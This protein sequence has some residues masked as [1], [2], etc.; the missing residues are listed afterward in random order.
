MSGARGP[1]VAV[2][3]AVVLGLVYW[4]WLG[5]IKPERERAAEDAKILFKGLNPDDTNEILLRKKG[6]ADVLLRKVDGQW[7]LITPI[8]APA[9][10]VAVGGLV[11]ELAAAKRNEI[12]VD[13]GANLRD[14]GLDQP[15]GEVTFKPA[16]P[17]AKAEVLFFGLDSPDGT[18]SYAVVDGKPAVFLTDMFVKNSVLKDAADLRDKTVW[19]FSPSDVEAVRS[20]IAGFTVARDKNGLWR[21]DAPPRHEPGKGSVVDAWLDD[22]SRLRAD[23]VPS[24]TGRGNFGLKRGKALRLK[25]TNGTL[26]VLTEGGKAKP[27]PGFYVQPAG[28]GPVFQ[29][30]A[31]LA[32][33]VEKDA[34]AL[35]D[36]NVFSFSTGDV[37]RFE[38]QRPKGTLSAVKTAGVWNWVPAPAAQPGAKPFDFYAFLSAMANT[39]LLRRLDAKAAPHTPAASVTFYGDNGV[40]LEK[41]VFGPRRDGGQVASSAMKNQTVLAAA[42]LLDSLPPDAPTRP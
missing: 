23:S 28:R 35:M 14:F 32:P 8:A 33:T 40:V 9:D 38:V 25:L 19:T 27:G 16:T 5:K 30:P 3:A 22:L 24:E 18:Q 20:D 42:N 13:Q 31:Y 7:R 29:L 6:S 4:A 41:A 26:L 34:Q 17:G 1:R 11:T 39:Q 37:V 10:P 36:L 2:G 15:S 21:V 12:I